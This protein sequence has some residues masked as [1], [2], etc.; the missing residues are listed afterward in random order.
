MPPYQ[1]AGVTVLTGGAVIDRAPSQS[2]CTTAACG[3]S[4]PDV[5]ACR[6]GNAP[7]NPSMLRST[8]SVKALFGDT[9]GS[10]APEKDG[11]SSEVNGV[12]A[13][14]AL[15]K[16]STVSSNNRRPLGKPAASPPSNPNRRMPGR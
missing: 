1:T 15:R 6:Y 4:K 14:P 13:A 7:R 8:P 3:E 10:F 9:L 5:G 16:M 2:Y 12:P 11:N